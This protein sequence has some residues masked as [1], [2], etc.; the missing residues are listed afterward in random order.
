MKIKENDVLKLYDGQF[1]YHFIYSKIE[2]ISEWK[3]FDKG[4]FSDEKHRFKLHQKRKGF[5]EK[6]N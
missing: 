1:N 6:S 5:I 4:P 3:I 2:S